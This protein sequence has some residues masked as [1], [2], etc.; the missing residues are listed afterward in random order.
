MVQDLAK[1]YEAYPYPYRDPESE[2][3]ETIV[4]TYMNNLTQ[5][6][7][8]IY[9]GENPFT[10]QCR[11]LVAGGGTGDATV[12]LATQLSELNPEAEVVHLDL[13]DTSIA[14]AKK[15]I[16]KRQLNNVTFHKESLLNL[17]EG[18]YGT[19][20]YINCSGVLH[21][22]EDPLAGAKALKSVLNKKGAIS[23]MLYGTYGRRIIYDVQ[24]MMR[25]VWGKSDNLE[26]L[27]DLTKGLI[28][29]LP[30]TNP[31]QNKAAQNANSPPNE[32]VDAYL[33]IRDRAYTVAQ[34]YE[35]IEQ[36]GM[37]I[38]SFIPEVMYDSLPFI[39][40]EKLH[41]RVAALSEKEQQAFAEMFFG[42]ID[43]H[44][45]YATAKNT[46]IPARPDPTNKKLIP[47]L[48]STIKHMID[49]MPQANRGLHFQQP[50]PQT[51]PNKYIRFLR[52][53]DGQKSIGEILKEVEIPGVQSME[54]K[55]KLWLEVYKILSGRGALYL[56]KP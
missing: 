26:P 6:R 47:S 1:Q 4:T 16:E 2:T 11:F 36:A 13:S 56:N 35:L 33:H 8:Y 17:P 42:F 28:A 18:K 25:M 50:V 15:R 3:N 32:I 55:T 7:Q 27:V 30:P 31:L 43:R 21:H 34:T 19:F 24:N 14:I 29:S 49:N 12:H 46:K 54:E 45:F 38:V 37:K 52:M 22:L 44:V 51:L 10:G 48:Q 41:K 53:V 39:T 20:D 9:G 23:I 5:I 40:D